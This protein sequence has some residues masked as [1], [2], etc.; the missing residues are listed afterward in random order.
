MK[1]FVYKVNH[2]LKNQGSLFI[3][4]IPDNFKDVISISFSHE[5][6]NY[7]NNHSIVVYYS[8]SFDNKNWSLWSIVDD[9][10]PVPEQ[11]PFYIGFKF[12]M[13]SNSILQ[14]VTIKSYRLL[15][16]FEEKTYPQN[17]DP[18]LNEYSEFKTFDFLEIGEFAANIDKK[19]NFWLNSNRGV[20]ANYWH[21]KPLPS[22]VNSSLR[23]YTHYKEEEYKCINL[24]LQED[25]FPEN[26]PEI[27]EWGYEFENFEV[28]VDKNYFES[29]FGLNEKPTN[30]DF[31]YFPI[32]NKM[33]YVSSNYLKKG[34]NQSALSYVL[35]LD[36][37]EDDKSVEKSDDTIKFLEDFTLNLDKIYSKEE[38]ED[39]QDIVDDNQNSNKTL[40]DDNVREYVDSNNTISFVDIRN[41][42]SELIKNM[43]NFSFIS[44]F[45]VALSYKAKININKDKSF[46]YASWIRLTKKLDNININFISQSISN[47]LLELEFD[48]SKT[49]IY[50][51]Y[52]ILQI[53]NKY[54]QIRGI[55]NNKFIIELPRLLSTQEQSQLTLVDS[56]NLFNINGEKQL[57]L[58]LLEDKILLM[59][60]INQRHFNI[61]PLDL[62]KWYCINFNINNQF[63]YFGTYI[64]NL[65]DD[66]TNSTSLLLHDKIEETSNFLNIDINNGSP[67]LLGSNLNISNIRFFNRCL[68][69]E[70]QHVINSCRILPK[71][72]VAD[73]ID[74]CELIFNNR[75]IG[76]STNKPNNPYGKI[77]EPS[78]L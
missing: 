46:G 57:S 5:F 44:K 10:V 13:S 7:T 3:H 25:Q 60:G 17:I 4:K 8:T 50:K 2:I 21:I 66:N 27:T 33:Y 67:Y 48:I 41:N 37:F 26:K 38:K 61:T 65:L 70:Y 31:L 39:I 76:T 16:E 59:Y 62:N 9:K 36:E 54:Y 23:T 32:E 19:L 77:G 6:E 42:G 69:F 47:D 15:I 53:G 68:D 74:N 28:E 1:E 63:K 24:F 78:G 34:T 43:Y 52:K 71:P 72:S 14:P 22:G 18:D 45:N 40:S 51:E 58:F 55:V 56:F 73:V 12:F 64:W 30:G 75:N 11:Q 49:S 29:I 20:K 35:Y